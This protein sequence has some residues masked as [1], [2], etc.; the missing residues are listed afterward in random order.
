[1][2][3]RI[4]RRRGLRH[5]GAAAGDHDSGPGRGAGD[6]RRRVR[7]GRRTAAAAA[8]LAGRVWAAAGAGGLV[9]PGPWRLTDPVTGESIAE[10]AARSHDLDGLRRFARPVSGQVAGPAAALPAAE[11]ADERCDLCAVPLDPRHGHVVALDQR[12][13]RCACR[14]CYLLFTPDGAG[15]GRFRAVPERYLHDPAH[16]L[17]DDRLGPTADPGVD[18]VL[19]R[20]QR[21]RP[22]GRLLSEPG[23]GHRVPAR[24]GLLGPA[25]AAPTRCWRRPAPDVEAVYV[26]RT[27]AGPEA[28]LVPDRRLLRAGRQGP[29]GLARDRRRRRGSPGHRDVRAGSARTQPAAAPRAGVR[30]R[31]SLLRGTRLRRPARRGG[32]KCPV[33]PMSTL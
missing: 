22:D 9:D 20:Q 15:G 14:P 10:P 17:T 26:T 7:R 1:M 4:S 11:P 25:P 23:R 33:P 2:R 28:F 8:D 6:D 3:V 31:H 12:S 29:V 16:P 32:H 21:P 18:G 24:P 27:G 5:P 30:P 19:L 13:L